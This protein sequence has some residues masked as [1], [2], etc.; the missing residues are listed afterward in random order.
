MD[1]FHDIGGTQGF[2]AVTKDAAPFHDEWEIK[3]SALMG[4]LLARKLFTMDEYRHAIERMEPRHYAC[5]SYFERSFVAIASLCVEKGVVSR[6]A[7]EAACGPGLRLSLPSGPGRSPT[8][9]L[10]KLRIGDSVY[11]QEECVPG[12]VRVPAYVRG[13]KGVI[14]GESPAYAFPDAHAHGLDAPKQ[15]TFDVRFDAGA[16][17][18]GGA[19]KAQVHVGL[20]HGYLRKAE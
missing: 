17:W 18:P 9:E 19:E 1:G 20:F 10:P 5:A 13:K 6:D 4:R 11:V 16:L 3:I 8:A 15:R 7:L 2:G 12:H 14:V